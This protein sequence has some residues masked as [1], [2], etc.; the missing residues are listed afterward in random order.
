MYATPAA[1]AATYALT[2]SA[3]AAPVNC[4]GLGLTPEP[5]GFTIAVP[6]PLR[7]VTIAGYVGAWVALI[8]LV[9][10]AALAEGEPE[11]V[12]VLTR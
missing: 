2:F 3:T 6:L 11:R 5:V 7:L 1:S 9:M 8:V 12:T 10:L 4:V